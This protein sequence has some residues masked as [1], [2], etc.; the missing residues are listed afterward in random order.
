MSTKSKLLSCVVYH[1][2]GKRECYYYFR[3]VHARLLGLACML[4]EFTTEYTS[5][6]NFL[7]EEYLISCMHQLI[8]YHKATITKQVS[9]TITCTLSRVERKADKSWHVLVSKLIKRSK[10]RNL[11]LHIRF[12]QPIHGRFDQIIVFWI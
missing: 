3:R 8:W 9:D 10:H 5:S 2:I 7:G 4:L 11:L 1:F 12:I 6:N